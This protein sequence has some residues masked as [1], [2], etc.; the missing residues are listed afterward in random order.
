M[1]QK[2]HCSYRQRAQHLASCVIRRPLR[3]A[4][5][6]SVRARLS[7]SRVVL[8]DQKMITGQS[9]SHASNTFH[10]NFC[11]K[12][13]SVNNLSSDVIHSHIT[14]FDIIKGQHRVPLSR[15]LEVSL[16]K[17]SITLCKTYLI[18]IPSLVSVNLCR[19]GSHLE[20]ALNSY[21]MWFNNG[22]VN[23]Q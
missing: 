7:P 9:R 11:V 20:F 10:V 18:Q 13:F 23:Y 4:R 17:C 1:Y 22:L 16:N 2:S 6:R 21:I 12:G 19:S 5:R 14:T 8:F 15:Y 3:L